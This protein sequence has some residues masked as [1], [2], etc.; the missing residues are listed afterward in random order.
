MQRF[1]R[2]FP[3]R[4]TQPS[5]YS[6]YFQHFLQLSKMASESTEGLAETSQH[7]LVYRVPLARRSA[8]KIVRCSRKHAELRG[9]GEGYSRWRCNPTAP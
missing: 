3:A 6:K 4:K 5:K 9:Y 7:S 8:R 1:A 2:A